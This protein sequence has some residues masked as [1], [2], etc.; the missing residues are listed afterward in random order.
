VVEKVMEDISFAA[1]DIVEKAIRIDRGYVQDH[2]KEILKS[3]DL[4]R[5]IL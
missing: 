2:L 1:P 4:R 5:F 3:Q